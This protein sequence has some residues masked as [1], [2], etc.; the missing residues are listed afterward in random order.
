MKLRH[1]PLSVNVEQAKKQLLDISLILD[2]LYNLAV[3][4]N[5]YFKHPE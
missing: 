2:I 1:L 3:H 5:S 4:A